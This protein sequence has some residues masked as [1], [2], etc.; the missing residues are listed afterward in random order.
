MRYEVGG[1]EMEPIKACFFQGLKNE[2]SPAKGR[3]VWPPGIRIWE[4]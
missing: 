4:T 3:R 2:K 1:N